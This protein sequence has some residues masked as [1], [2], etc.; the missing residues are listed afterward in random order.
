MVTKMS[1]QTVKLIA[2]DMDFTLLDDDKQVSPASLAAIRFAAA[3]GVQ[4]VPDTGRAPRSI[5][6]ELLAMPEI[7]YAITMN[8]SRVDRLRPG[9]ELL[10]AN[11]IPYETAIPLL[12]A[13]KTEETLLTLFIDGVPYIN[14]D[15]Y[16]K[17]RQFVRPEDIRYMMESRTPTDSVMEELAK[18]PDRLFK[19]SVLIPHCADKEAMKN[20]IRIKFPTVSVAESNRVIEITDAAADKGNAVLQ[21]A[22][23]LGIAPEETAAIGDSNND[24]SMIQKAG[25][26]AAMQNASPDVKAAADF[27]TEADNNHDGAA[28]AIYRLLRL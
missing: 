24:L 23:L 6:G 2:V 16:P 9:K 14:R 17:I 15:E 19:I 11:A 1:R 5:P 10:A 18:A 20:S 22:G 8:G 7:Q 3:R 21:L 4:I 27:I 12:Q 25:V 28:E 13:L 26:G